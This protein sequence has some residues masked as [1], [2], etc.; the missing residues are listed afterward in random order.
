MKDLF[1][2]DV[3]TQKDFMLRSGALY[4][5]DA[6]RIVPALG[7]LFDF[8]VKNGIPVLSSMDVHAPDDP[9]FGQFPPHC[10]RGTDGARKIGETLLADPLVFPAAPVEDG[11]AEAAADAVRKNRQLIVEKATFDVFTTPAAERLVRALPPRAAVFG[12]ATEYC[13]KAACLGLRRLGV[14][15]A[16]VADAVRGIAPQTEKAA[17]EELAAAGVRF[18]PLE[19]LADL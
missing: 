1:F 10:V 5:P 17:T 8:A 13:V 9:E 2:F 14:Q 19:T 7:R 4:V 11:L 16:V 12:V 15:V 3:D 6:E 18:V